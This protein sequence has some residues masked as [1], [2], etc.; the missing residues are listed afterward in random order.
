MPCRFMKLTACAAL[1][2]PMLTGVAHA[3]DT[4]RVGAT[5]TAVPFNFLD[6]KTNTLQ[7]VMIDITQALGKELG[8]T[9]ELRPIPL[10]DWYRRYRPTRLT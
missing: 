1:M 7:G 9:P 8:F 10:P 2:L 3:Q 4:L 5:P 6:T